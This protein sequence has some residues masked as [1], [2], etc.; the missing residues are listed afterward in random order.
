MSPP[1][2]RIG[3]LG[4][5]SYLPPTVVTNEELTRVVDTS[6]SWI[7]RRTGIRSRRVLG[8]EET[9][10]DMAV[11]ASR[12]ALDAAGI[13]AGELDDIRVGVNTWLRFPSLATQVQK[14]LGARR[15]SASD[16]SAGC[17]GFVYAVEEAHQRLYT[18]KLLYRRDRLA[19][20]V[21]V[22]GLSHITN[23]K[24]RSTCVLLGDGAG[25]V[26]LGE[27]EKGG[28]LA[29]HTHADGRH[30]DL[31]YSDPPLEPQ[32]E[33]SSAE[34]RFAHESRGPRPFLHMD[35]PRVY[36]IAVKT[37]VKDVLSV[38]AK[39]NRVSERAVELDDIAYFYPHQANLR[40]LEMVAKKIDVPVERFYTDGVVEYGNTSTASIPI[41]YV[42]N[43]DR[44]L[45][46]TGERYEVDVAFGAGFASGAILRHEAA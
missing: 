10:L 34:K 46:A 28:I 44:G 31:L 20:V 12:R 24:D 32:V 8:R 13:A 6:D 33:T 19:L 43:R 29:T 14:V 41:G 27:V 36:G 40:I 2:V 30:G 5:G 11:E 15:A 7:Q 21:G 38:L 39:H 45:G 23:W 1:E 22:D 17:A 35:G 3:Y 4:C 26:V 16:V 25:A 42:D 37:M 9:I 18:E